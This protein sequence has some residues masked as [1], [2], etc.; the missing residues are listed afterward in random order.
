[1]ARFLKHIGCS[2]CGSSDANAV[3][4]DGSQFCFSC[5]KPTSSKVSGYVASSLRPDAVDEKKVALPSDIT[6][7]YPEHA[8]AWCNKYEIS[9]E[10]MLQNNMVYSPYRDQLIFTFYDDTKNLLAYQAR[11][12]N[13]V[14]KAKRYYT[15]GDVNELLPIY[16][17]RSGSINEPQASSINNRRL[18]LVEDCLSAIKVAATEALGADAM[19]LLGSGISR[20][21]LSRLRPFYDLLDVFLD[22]DM[23]HKSLS[24]VKQAQL[25]GFRTRPV[26]S[27]RDPKEHSYLELKDLLQQSTIA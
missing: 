16:P 1:M 7:N 15:C 26:Q 2:R 22:P 20:T 6:Q 18:V 19:P 23:W 10:Q 21:K 4:E 17:C 27:D 24:I 9:V 12:L 8:V 14:S 5:R 11:N 3:Y 13:A 25:L